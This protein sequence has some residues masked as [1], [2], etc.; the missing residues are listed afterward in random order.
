M[1]ISVAF[2]QFAQEI[3][4]I[5]LLNE[6]RQLPMRVNA[7]VQEPLYAVLPQVSEKLL[8]ALLD[9]ADGVEFH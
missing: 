7:D 8:R 4:Q 3:G 1:N 2:C 9:E 5:L 6:T